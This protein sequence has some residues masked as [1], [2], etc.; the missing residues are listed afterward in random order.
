MNRATLKVNGVAVNYNQAHRDI[1]AEHQIN[2]IRSI[3][4]YGIVIWGADTLAAY[5]SALSNIGVRRLMSYLEK[6]LSDAMIIS[7]FEPN[8][9]T[10]R[11]SLKLLVESF[12]A[13]V[14]AARGLYW[15]SVICDNSNNPLTQV[16]DGDLI[17]DIFVDPTVHTKRIHLN[18]VIARS[19]GIQYAVNYMSMAGQSSV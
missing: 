3:K 9:E 7:V 10:L 17:I 12:L 4:G 16:A 5:P 1:F 14:K 18:A 6:S 15:Y 2:P 8:T 13:P 19:G 11:T